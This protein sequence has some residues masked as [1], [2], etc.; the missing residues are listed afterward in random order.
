MQWELQRKTFRRR[1]QDDIIFVEDRKMTK[2]AKRAMAE[3]KKKDFYGGQLELGEE[4]GEKSAF[5]YTWSITGGMLKCKAL[6]KFEVEEESENKKKG[7]PV[8][9]GPEQYM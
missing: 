6:N 1:W 5:G 9:S 4:K 2:P 3:R 7:R 8:M